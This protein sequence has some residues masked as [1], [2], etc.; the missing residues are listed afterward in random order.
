MRN[1]I[2]RR[3]LA[4][5]ASGAAVVSLAAV[6]VIAQAPVTTPDWDKAARASHRENSE[7]LAKFEIPMSLEPAFHFKT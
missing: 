7:V 1:E 4:G 2:T 3:Q 5:I 6:K